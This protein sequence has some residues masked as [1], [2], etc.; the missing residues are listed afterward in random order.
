M[1]L[2]LRQTKIIIFAL[3]LLALFS[4]SAQSPKA[5]PIFY[6]FGGPIIV[7]NYACAA[8]PGP[9]SANVFVGPPS[10]GAFIYIPWATQTYLFTPPYRP[11]QYILGT[12]TGYS[13]CMVPTPFGP[14]VVGA[15]MPIFMEGTS[16]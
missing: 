3:F 9:G 4:Y 2:G 1:T 12:A 11:G 7:A 16:L 5:V 13:P 10:P 6:P 15:G 8:F 14:V